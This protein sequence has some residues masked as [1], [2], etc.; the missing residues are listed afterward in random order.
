MTIFWSGRSVDTCPFKYTARISSANPAFGSFNSQT[1]ISFKEIPPKYR[2]STTHP[3]QSTILLLLRNFGL[4]NQIDGPSAPS[5][6]KD[7]DLLWVFG[8]FPP[9]FSS[10]V[11]D[12][13]LRVHLY[14]DDS[15][16]LDFRTSE[17]SNIN[18]RLPP[19]DFI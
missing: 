10:E 1:F 19:M 8:P 15:R 11:L 3:P 14:I 13:E 2:L 7:Q 16:R 5:S 12:L 6:I 4:L 17:I 18:F 9:L